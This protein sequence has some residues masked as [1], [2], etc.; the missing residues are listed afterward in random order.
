[1]CKKLDVGSDI[2]SIFSD[3][4]FQVTNGKITL[5]NWLAINEFSKVDFSDYIVLLNPQRNHISNDN[6]TQYPYLQTVVSDTTALFGGDNAYLIISGNYMYHY[7]DDD[8][9]PIPEGESDIS[10]G[11]YA[12]DA[13]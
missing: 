9:Y 4:V 11:R 8:P 10:E 7:Y 2:P 3:L 1:M 12:M 6:I 5:D 13:G